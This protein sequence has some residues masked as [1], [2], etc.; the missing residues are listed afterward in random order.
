MVGSGRAPLSSF[1]HQQA[2]RLPS[3][4]KP[5]VHS[6]SR[7]GRP[8][9]HSSSDSCNDKGCD[10]LCYQ[11][12]YVGGKCG[13][14]GTCDCKKPDFK[15]ASTCDNYGDCGFCWA[16]ERCCYKEGGAQ[17]SEKGICLCGASGREDKCA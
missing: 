11:Q 2:P 6:F 9:Q 14:E 10:E 8:V 4:H 15:P 16:Y 17:S 13:S 5:T 3:G 12:G 1:R 7:I